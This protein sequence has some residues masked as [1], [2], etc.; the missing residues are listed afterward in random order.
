MY[1]KNCKKKAFTSGFS[2]KKPRL[3]LVFLV[4]FVAF[5]YINYRWHKRCLTKLIH[6]Y[7]HMIFILMDK[8][9]MTNSL[10]W[11]LQN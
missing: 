4:V 5:R 1:A 2:F 7:R 11:C 10:V 6:Y 3:K 9:I 8:Y